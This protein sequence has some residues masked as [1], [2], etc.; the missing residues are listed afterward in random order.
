MAVIR[1]N[2]FFG[3]LPWLHKRKLPEGYAE[4]SRN[5]ALF[6][7]TLKPLKAT[8]LEKAAATAAT[9]KTIFK[10][11]DATWLEWTGEVDPVRS[12]IANDAYDRVFYTGTDLPRV[13]ANDMVSDGLGGPYPS[14]SYRLGVPAPTGAPAVT[15]TGTATDASDLAETRFY[16][17]TYVNSWG[18]E[19]EPSP[20]SAEVE[21]R[22]GQAVSVGLPGAPTGPYKIDLVN[23][24]R[25][26]EGLYQLVAS[27]PVANTSYS[28]PHGSAVYE[29]LPSITWSMPPD[30]LH[31]LTS[32]AGS[33]LVGLRGNEVLFSEVGLPHAWPVDYRRP[34]DYDAVGVGTFGS[35]IVVTTKG[36]P[37]VFTGS[38]P[39]AMVT[40]ET[41]VRQACV[42][43]RGIVSMGFGVIY[44]SPDGLVMVDGSGARLMDGL[45]NR[46]SWAAINPASIR[47]VLWERLYLAFYDAGAGGIGAFV[48]NPAQP[49]GGVAFIDSGVVGGLYNHLVDDAVYLATGTEIRRWEAG[50]NHSMTYR[51]RSYE[52]GTPDAVGALQVFADSYPV[53]I[54]VY[55]DDQVQARIDVHSDRPV[56]TG[57]RSRA[58]KY[59]IEVT[60]TAEVSEV[61]LASTMRELKGV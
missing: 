55:A 1:L 20:A 15:V 31:S 53:T 60:G 51:S 3:Q 49:E 58:R 38:D 7:G 4:I 13:T 42:A 50:A 23:I 25:T 30:D 36:V 56:R 43:K 11:N 48:F 29:E 52:L 14:A 26:N 21:L 6:A 32:V 44:P 61:L 28:D 8:A 54:T 16:R 46:E 9:P 19:G 5:V 18:E 40:A 39:A 47:A 41:E 17:V 45:F 24:Y 37:Y 33:F 59:Q 12:I 57:G 27:V 22:P 34:L 10:Y 2:K 35:T